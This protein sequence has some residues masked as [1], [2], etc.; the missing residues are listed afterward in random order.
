MKGAGLLGWGKL[1]LALP[2]LLAEGL[3]S[4]DSRPQ[5]RQGSTMRLGLRH[6]GLAAACGAALGTADA[7]GAAAATHVPGHAGA[8]VAIFDVEAVLDVLHARAAFGKMVGMVLS[9]AAL[10]RTLKCDL[11]SAD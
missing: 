4:G 1:V 7:P 2:D 3:A 6:S 11:A 5:S 9:K 10:D 8:G